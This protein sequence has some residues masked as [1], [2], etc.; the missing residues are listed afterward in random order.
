MEERDTLVQVKVAFKNVLDKKAIYKSVESDSLATAAME[1]ARVYCQDSELYKVIMTEKVHL[2]LNGK[3]VGVDDWAGTL[4]RDDDKILITPVLAGDV[5]GSGLLG[6]ILGAVLIAVS[7]LMPAS[8]PLWGALVLS[9]T[10]VFMMGAAMLLGGLMAMFMAPDLP[11]MGAVGGLTGKNS[12]T[13]T[14]S[15]ISTQARP[16][17]PVPVVYG[18]HIV[19]GNL[20]N[21]FTE[22]QG[23][24]DYLYMLIAMAEGEIE[25]ICTEDKTNEIC[26]TSNR[27]SAAYKHPHIT[28]DDQPFRNFSNV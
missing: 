26:T 8:I 19:G 7:I 22:R 15:G 24:D 28:L 3:H 1:Y 27:S 10:A 12:P 25:G 16:D 13:Y 23:E 21:I 5:A 18:K 4:L 9:N 6:I 17:A 20:V 11:T 14:W 2:K